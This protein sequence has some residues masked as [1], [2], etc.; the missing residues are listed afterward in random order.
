M[1]VSIM[2]VLIGIMTMLFGWYN[3]TRGGWPCVV[4]LMI[5]CGGAFFAGITKKEDKKK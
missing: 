1:L 4:G 5:I 3:N 2:V